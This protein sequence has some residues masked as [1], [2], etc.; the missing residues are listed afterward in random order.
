[1]RSKLARYAVT[2]LVACA[3]LATTVPATADT[4]SVRDPRDPSLLDISEISHRHAG[5][6]YVVH[7]VEFRERFAKRLLVHRFELYLEGRPGATFPFESHIPLV[8]GRTL[9]DDDHIFMRFYYYDVEMVTH[10][11]ADVRLRKHPHAAV[12]V[13]PTSLVSTTTPF[14]YRW[15]ARA[16]YKPEG[17]P[18][19]DDQTPWLWHRI[20]A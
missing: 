15:V 9:R 14:T 20:T 16:V 18:T 4:S 8:Y 10:R 11:L 2:A 13:I 6:G 19:V 12:V 5:A 1:M 17:E 3:A 7:R